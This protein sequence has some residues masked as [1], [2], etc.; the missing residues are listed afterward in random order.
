MVRDCLLI[1]RRP[2]KYFNGVSRNSLPDV[3]SADYLTCPNSTEHSQVSS[4]AVGG[5]RKGVSNVVAFLSG[6]AK[7]IFLSAQ[8][9]FLKGRVKEKTGFWKDVPEN[10]VSLKKY[11]YSCHSG[12][13]LLVKFHLG[14]L[15]YFTTYC[16]RQGDATLLSVS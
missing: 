3:T 7:S 8:K 4:S 6:T 13:T 15:A 11:S 16:S 12:H 5:D 10:N 9:T 1:Y 14:V 2:Y